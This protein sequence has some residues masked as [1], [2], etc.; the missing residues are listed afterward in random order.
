MV[1]LSSQPGADAAPEVASR[2]RVTVLARTWREWRFPVPLDKRG[3]PW[4]IVVL[5]SGNDVPVVVP[6]ADLRPATSR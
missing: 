5:Y 6:D 2:Q 4:R 1:G 3:L